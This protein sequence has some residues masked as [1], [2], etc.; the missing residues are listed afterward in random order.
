MNASKLSS[1]M[2]T[3]TPHQPTTNPQTAY[4][5]QTRPP[6]PKTQFLTPK[7]FRAAIN[8][9]L[10]DPLVSLFRLASRVLQ[11]IFALAA[12]T[13]Y[14]IELKHETVGS[15][16]NSPFIYAE[17]VFGLSLITLIIDSMTIRTYRFTWTV[18]WTL[19]IL[20]FV[21]FAVFYTTYYTGLIEPQYLETDIGRMKGAV[22][23]DLINALLWMG[24]ALFSTTMCCSG[25]RA[26]ARGKRDQWRARRNNKKAIKSMNKMEEGTIQRPTAEEEQLPGY[27]EVSSA[28]GQ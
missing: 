2:P 9:R 19:C 8:D 6:R 26:K 13:C 27:E 7:T 25:L 12:G 23:V 5:Q 22:W 21:V 20:W 11:F 28:G 1:S 3:S 17:V 24:S 16:G 4:Y 18:E 10:D 15:D 14:S